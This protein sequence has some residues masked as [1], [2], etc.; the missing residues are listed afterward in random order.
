MQHE[1]ADSFKAMRTLPRALPMRALIAGLCA[2]V[3]GVSA[4]SADEAKIERAPKDGI[5]RL[6]G[7][8]GPDTAFRK[9]ADAWQEKTGKK[10]EIIA[11]PEKK[12]APDAQR[13][14]DILWGTSQQSMTAFLESFKSFSSS[15]VVPIYVRPAVIGVRKGNPKHIQGFDDLLKDGMKIVVTEGAGVYNTSGTG[16]WEDVAGRL[17]RL[18][19]IAK[20][21]K[22]IVAYAKGSGASLR[23][24]NATNADAW[25]T[26][27]DWPITHPDVMDY[28]EIEPE[29]R[30]WRDVNVTI[31]PD[32]D[33]DA[34]AFVAFLI[35]EEGQKIMGRE[36]WVR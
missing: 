26:W 28:V 21:R 4:A 16:V 5:L 35:S 1:A 11:G 18:D 12:W 8:G 22:N 29:R 2:C 3:L 6:Y 13:N 36:G 25:I 10:V 9:V 17:G 20:F 33:D 24:F 14:A 27:P 30:I 7:A 34:K 23:A 31:A 19:D 15:D 32:A